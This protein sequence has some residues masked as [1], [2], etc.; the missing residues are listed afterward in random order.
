MRHVLEAERDNLVNRLTTTRP[1]DQPVPGS[2]IRHL[3]DNERDRLVERIPGAYYRDSQNVNDGPGPR[4]REALGEER[5]NIIGH[6]PGGSHHGQPQG[7]AQNEGF[8]AR[9]RHAAEDYFHDTFPSY[10]L[11]TIP[12]RIFHAPD[13]TRG[14]ARNPQSVIDHV[15]PVHRVPGQGMDI[16]KAEIT[17]SYSVLFRAFGLPDHIYIMYAV[18]RW[19]R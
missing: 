1:N 8:G 10:H 4:L 5:E 18:C 7:G 6:I 12:G 2:Q 16:E 17:V 14:S 19:E 3:F 13:G 9:L 15:V 11:P